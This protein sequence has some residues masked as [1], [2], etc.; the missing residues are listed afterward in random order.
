M[1]LAKS[2]IDSQ[3]CEFLYNCVEG[4][5]QHSDIFPLSAYTIFI[6]IVT[7]LAAALCNVSGGS[8][9]LFKML[10]LVIALNY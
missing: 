7:G 4:I 3:E 2:C 5:C 1:L 8:M 6:Y 9:G 10:L